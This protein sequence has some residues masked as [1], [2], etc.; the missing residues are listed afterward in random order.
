M[1]ENKLNELVDKTVGTKGNLQIPSYWMNKTLKDIINHF[2]TQ[3][4]DIDSNVQNLLTRTSDLQNRLDRE[5]NFE[6]DNVY[7]SYNNKLY[8]YAN[9]YTR[10]KLS[11]GD[12]PNV[13]LVWND[14]DDVLKEYIIE[15]TC[16]TFGMTTQAS[17]V[18]DDTVKWE[19][20]EYPSFAENCVTLI[21]IT[22]GLGSWKLFK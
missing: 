10:I 7:I 3:D 5:K 8:V 16:G 11:A 18:F 15:A 13:E 12:H 1:E 21:K 9:Y 2:N 14:V 20:D 19:N 6:I 17:L 22:N 4:Q